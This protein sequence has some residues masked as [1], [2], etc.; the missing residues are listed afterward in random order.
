MIKH[1]DQMAIDARLKE[2]RRET[3]N[4][5]LAQNVPPNDKGKGLLRSFLDVFGLCLLIMGQYHDKQR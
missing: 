2:L 5:Q 1:L 4:E 3:E